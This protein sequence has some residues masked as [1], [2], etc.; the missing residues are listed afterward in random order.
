MITRYTSLLIRRK[1]LIHMSKSKL[2]ALKWLI[3]NE[4]LKNERV[5]I[6]HERIEEAEKI[7]RY[8]KE[9]EF[10]VGIYHTSMPLYQRLE[11]ISGYR[12]ETLI[13]SF[14]SGS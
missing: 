8:L 2:E 14:V 5:L 11:N 1:G 9:Q 6:F 13:S 3:S 7:Y 12:K 4:D 10:K